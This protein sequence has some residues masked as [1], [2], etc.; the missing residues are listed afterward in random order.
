[1]HSD[2]FDT[3]S[4]ECENYKNIKPKKEVSIQELNNAVKEEYDKA[5][6]EA[7]DNP[8]YISTRNESLENDRHPITGVAFEKKVV[9]LSNGDKIEGVFPKFESLFDA[10][11]SENLYLDS[12]K[13]QFKECNKQLSGEIS[14]NAKLRLKFSEEQIEQIKEGVLDGTAPDGYVWHHDAE[15][16]KIQLVDFEIHSRTGHTGGRAIWGGGS[17]NR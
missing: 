9:E 11:I 10:K 12:D 7:K 4:L 15:T 13:E 1:M 8:R 14:N 2:V 16:G 3:K 6:I 5:A 17:D